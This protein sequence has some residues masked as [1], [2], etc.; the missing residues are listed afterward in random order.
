M[1]RYIY[2][3]PDNGRTI[4]RRDMDNPNAERELYR[5]EQPDILILDED[6]IVKIK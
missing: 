5:K 6:V 2:E 1:P 3:S 4:Y